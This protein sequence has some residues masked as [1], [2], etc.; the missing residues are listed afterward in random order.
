MLTFVTG[1]TVSLASSNPYDDP[2]IDPA[3]LTHDFDTYTMVQALNDVESLITSSTWTGYVTGALGGLAD[4][5][6][7]DLKLAFARDN[8]F[9]VN[10]AV[11]T[12]YMSP[13]GSTDGVINPDLTVK[14]A[15]KLRIV[16]ASV[17]VSG[18]LPLR[19]DHL[20]KP[21]CSAGHPTQPS[22][23]SCLYGSRESR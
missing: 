15:V 16:D 7:D 14:G 12:A 23:G 22:S 9:N 5:T 21:P 2:L 13:V 10:H 4:A 20:V 6:T 17:F 3:F 11:G 19:L 8:S 18:P 1:G